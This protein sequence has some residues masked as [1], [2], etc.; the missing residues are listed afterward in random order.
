MRIGVIMGGVSSEKQVS[1]MTGNEMIAHLDKS[2]YDIVPIT[3]NEKMDLIEKAKTLILRCSH[4]TEN[5]E[6]MGQF[7]ERLKV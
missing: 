1:I 4:Y 3:L 7:K 6:K 2:K 5:T